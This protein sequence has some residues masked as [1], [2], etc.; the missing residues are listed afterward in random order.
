[1]KSQPLSIVSDTHGDMIDPLMEA[2]FF[3]WL[4]DYKPAIRIH[5]GDLFDFRPLRNGASLE[6]RQEGMRPDFDAGMD[7]IKRYFA[8]GSQKWILW[9]NHDQR[10]FD[11][12]QTN[13]GPLADHAKDIIRQI[14]TLLTKLKV[15]TLP[16]DSR[17]GVLRLG[18]LKVLHGFHSG[19]G[20]ARAQ[21]AIYGNCIF[22]HDHSQS[23]APV[24]NLDG[25]AMAMGTGCM[26][27]ID[28]AYNARQTNKLRH[29]QG[30]V[31][32]N[33]CSDGT[34]N[35]FQAKRVGDSVYAATDFKNY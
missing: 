4:A 2:K 26:T 32:G 11:L 30:W 15:Q 13:S 19:V 35:A 7:F 24:P 27:Q 34:Y 33:L 10:L 31:Y 14:K 17:L 1:M 20:A 5:A 12:A 21:A 22:G 18:H 9:G 8:G 29:Q 23:I 16:Y 28:M 3:D 6:E 25:P